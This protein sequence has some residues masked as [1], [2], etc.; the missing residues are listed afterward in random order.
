MFLN[1]VMNEKRSDGKFQE[2]YNLEK[3]P[4]YFRELK[5]HCNFSNVWSIT[6]GFFFSSRKHQIIILKYVD[7]VLR[8]NKSFF[9]QR[10]VNQPV[11]TEF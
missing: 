4:K 1:Q 10:S 9:D 2:I 11:R 3:F 8:F 6:L 5:T 7:N